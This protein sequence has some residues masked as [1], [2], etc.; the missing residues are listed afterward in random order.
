MDLTA[1]MNLN[2]FISE[3]F[4]IVLIPLLGVLVKYF[5]NFVNLKAKELKEKT[6]NDKYR[7]YIT[8]L[9]NT[10]ISAV[11]ATNQTYVNSLKEQGK[12]DKEAQIE[13]FNKTYA[14]VMSV[15]TDEA[16]ECLNE[17][18]GDLK[19]YIVTSIEEQVNEQKL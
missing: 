17:A 11:T 12:F 9:Q 8:L 4:T 14:A 6:E 18:I 1:P 2:V 3:L 5:V 10:I 16:Q 7:K 19:T 13:A 15:L